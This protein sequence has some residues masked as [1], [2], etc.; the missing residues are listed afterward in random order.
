MLV[1][2]L[3]NAADHV[4]DSTVNRGYTRARHAA[5]HATEP[6][7]GRRCGCAFAAATGCAFAAATGV[8]GRVTVRMLESSMF[9][10]LSRVRSPSA[11][12]A[13]PGLGAIAGAIAVCQ[14]TPHAHTVRHRA[15]PRGRPGRGIGATC[16]CCGTASICSASASTGPE[17]QRAAGKAAAARST[18]IAHR[19]CCGARRH[20][21]R[22]LLQPGPHRHLSSDGRHRKVANAR[23]LV[24][25]KLGKNQP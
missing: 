5:G 9:E 18:R 19:D 20:D 11:H 4:V 6:E 14:A 24:F 7:A 23:E 1:R 25:E 13:A 8:D 17:G 15:S 2:P 10:V 3:H 22:R 16:R 12:T 21:G